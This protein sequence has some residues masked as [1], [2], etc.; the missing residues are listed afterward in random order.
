[1]RYSLAEIKKSLGNLT[2]ISIDSVIDRYTAAAAGGEIRNADNFIK[3]CLI[4]VG[5][6][7]GLAKLAKKSGSDGVHCGNPSFDVDEYVKLSMM[8]LNEEN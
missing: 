3:T 8:G 6:A 5:R 7:E 1:M 2:T 4:S